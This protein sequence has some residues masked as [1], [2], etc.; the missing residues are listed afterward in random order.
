MLEIG[1]RAHDFGTFASADELGRRIAQTKA[2]SFIQ[3]ALKK[4]IPS[5]RPWQEWDEEYISSIASDL[6]D[7]GVSIAVI[8][9]YIN[10]IH[11]DKERRREEIRRFRKSLSLTRA[12]GCP[13]VGT[14]TGTANADG[15]YSPATSDPANIE[16][17]KA[18]LSELLD[19]A[20][21]DDAFVAIE[22]V[23]RSHPISSPERLR[24]ILDTF[25]TD[26]LK[27]IFDPVNLIPYT[28][29]AESDGVPLEIPTEEAEKRFV[30]EILD[31][32]G[33]R[34]V[35][36]HCKDY[37]L[38]PATGL[39]VGDIPALTGHFRWKSFA[40]ELHARSI[41]VPWL[42]ENHDPATAARTAETLEKF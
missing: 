5:C 36:I 18:G 22:A 20:E 24:K 9:C 23:S 1:F 6:R 14:E 37:Y 3:L 16:I 25:R 7:H 28:G 12:F 34:I 27:V 10:P 38:D 2:P 13:I 40:E 39:K 26:R 41:S 11:P 4:V 8:G 30:K 33:D 15:G 21:K 32:C 29:I 17:L 42:L 35:A 31:I 19:E